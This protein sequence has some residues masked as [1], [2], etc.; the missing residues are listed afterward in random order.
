MKDNYIYKYE[1]DKYQFIL[2]NKK[3]VLDSLIDY[4]VNDLESIYDDLLDS[5]N[6]IIYDYL[7]SKL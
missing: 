4:R 2:A 5:N 1:D 7:C 3:D 6:K